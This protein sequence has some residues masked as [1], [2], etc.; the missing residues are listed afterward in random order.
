MARPDKLISDE[1][2]PAFFEE[3]RKLDV[4]DSWMRWD[5]DK[6]VSAHQATREHQELA[7]RAQTPLGSLI[8]TA[9]AQ[10]LYVEGYRRS[11]APEDKG[12][13]RAWQVNGMDARQ[14]ALHRA[15]LGYG[16]AYNVVLP[17]STTLGER[18]PVIRP[19]SPRR[20][21][22]FWLDPAEDDWPAYFLRCDPAKIDGGMG[23]SIRLYD[24]EVVWRYQAGADGSALKYVTYEEHGTGVCPVVRYAN[25]MDL[26]GRTPGEIE[27]FIPIMARIDQTTFDRLLIQRHQSWKVRTISGMTLPDSDEAMNLAKLKLSVADI[28]IAEDTDTKF[29]TL[30]ETTPDG[31]INST[32]FDLQLLSAVSQTP[33]YE[34]LGDLIN[35]SAEALV[36]ARSSLARKAKERKESF[37]EKHGQTLRLGSRIMGDLDAAQDWQG[38]VLWEDTEGRS[39]GQAADALGKMATMLGV[40]VEMLWEQIPGWTQ[41]DV[42][43][44]KELVANGDSITQLLTELAAGQSSQTDGLVA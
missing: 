20:G 32:K 23:W 35:L 18:I 11:D 5:H 44:A 19:V 12:P 7:K 39:L 4:I 28:L 21:M 17:G 38:G 6:P 36:A 2:L 37:G 26:E 22:A 9:A 31:T 24:D 42:E 34:L 29:G 10:E 41:T 1:L 15:A 30:P 27:P 13:W 3:R 33:S 8:V 25:Q 16:E 14:I 43:R 40:P